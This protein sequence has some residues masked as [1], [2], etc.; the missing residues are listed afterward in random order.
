[1][2][3]SSAPQ[4]ALPIEQDVSLAT[5]PCSPCGHVGVMSYAGGATP[6]ARCS[7]TVLV[8]SRVQSSANSAKD[9]AR[10]G[11]CLWAVGRWHC[12]CTRLRSHTSEA[13]VRARGPTLLR[14]ALFGPRPR[15]PGPVR[16]RLAGLAG[17]TL[18]RRALAGGP[19]RHQLALGRS[20]A[21]AMRGP[22][23][24]QPAAL[25]EQIAA[26][27]VPGNIGLRRPASAKHRQGV[28]DRRSRPFKERGNRCQ[29]SASMGNLPSR[30]LRSLSSVPF[31]RSIR[32]SMLLH[33]ARIAR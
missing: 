27:V 32:A 25:V 17:G 31:Q 15:A 13:T 8:I 16:L 19:E 2:R 23:R 20:R 33:A 26:P 9:R 24:H 14:R 3:R 12:N 28:T 29:A 11:F 7:A 22:I 10:S 21:R 30:L 18:S 6:F 4:L 5:T 1:M